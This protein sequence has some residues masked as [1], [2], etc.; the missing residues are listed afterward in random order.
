MLIENE[1]KKD[2]NSGKNDEIDDY[3]SLMKNEIDQNK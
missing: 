2:R 1:R 3:W